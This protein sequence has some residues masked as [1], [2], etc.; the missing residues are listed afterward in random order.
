MFII[1]FFSDNQALLSKVKSE[2]T[3]NFLSSFKKK[4]KINITVLN[5]LKF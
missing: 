2:E 1:I 5:K 4:L 3:E